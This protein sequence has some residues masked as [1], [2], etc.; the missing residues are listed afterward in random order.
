M[1]AAALLADFQARGVILLA[2][3]GRLRWRPKDALSTEDVATLA[4]HKGEL[5][6]MLATV[7]TITG[8]AFEPAADRWDQSEANSLARAAFARLNAAKGLLD[9]DARRELER[10]MAAVDH[11]YLAR[12]RP[13][14]DTAVRAFH[15]L[16]DA[17]P[18]DSP[19]TPATTPTP[20]EDEDAEFCR[21][22]ERSEGLAPGS[23]FLFEPHQ[24]S[25]FCRCHD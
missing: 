14:F 7:P 10:R 17:Q 25:P 20:A 16:L 18:A 3:D 23:V 9:P 24:C 12:Y 6:A 8:D 1:T 13:D 21:A 22:I 5:L 11:A 15:E 19:T 4:A 2:V